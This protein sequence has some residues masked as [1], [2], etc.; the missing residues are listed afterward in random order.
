MNSYRLEVRGDWLSPEGALVS[1]PGSIEFS[2]VTSLSTGTNSIPPIRVT[3]I[4]SSRDASVSALTL[5]AGEL[6]LGSGDTLVVAGAAILNGGTLNF[7]LSG[8][9]PRVLDVRGDVTVTGTVVGTA[10][11]RAR[12]LCAGNWSSPSSF[13]LPAGQVQMVGAD[14]TIGGPSPT[15]GDLQLVS[16]V[17]TLLSETRATSLGST[18]GSTAGT[19]W[20]VMVAGSKAGLLS[21]GSN[22]I[23]KL[24]VAS[25]TLSV[26]DAAAGEFELT[27]GEVTIENTAR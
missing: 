25:G 14:A 23:A 6:R 9:N 2:G 27:G 15:F 3:G 26:Q 19:E 11:H 10:D 1:G 18:G 22:T 12:L 17:R 8:S 13:F 16:G 24:R 5:D 20:M 21:T 7:S 4:V